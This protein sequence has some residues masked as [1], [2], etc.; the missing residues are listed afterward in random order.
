MVAGPSR[1]GRTGCDIRIA[2][3]P[4]GADR[5]SRH[6]RG[7]RARGPDRRGRGRVRPGD[8]LQPRPARLPAS[9]PHRRGRG[10]CHP[11]RTDHLLRPAG[12]PRGAPGHRR[13]GGG[14][15][16]PGP[17]PASGW[18]CTPGG[19]PP[20]GSTQ[21][22]Y[23]EPGD[24]VIYPSPGYP[25]F[26]SF[27]RYIGGVPVPLRL[28][29]ESGFNFTG[30]DL[31]RLITARTKMIYLN[32]PSNP[33]G[34]VASREQLA[35][36]AAVILERTAPRPGCTRTRPT[37]PSSSTGPA[38]SRSPRCRAWRSAPSSPPAPP[39]PTRGPGGRVGWGVFPTG[40]RGPGPAAS[41]HQL[42]RLDPALQPTGGQDGAGVAGVPAGDRGDGVGLPAATRPGGG[43]AQRHRRDHLPEPA[44]RLLRVSQRLRGAAAPRRPGPVRGTAGRGQAAVRRRPPCCSCSC[45][46][47]TGWPPWTAARSVCSAP[48]AST[49]CGSPS[50]P[51][52]R[53][54]PRRCSGSPAA[55]GDA[56]GFGEFVSSGRRLTL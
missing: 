11:L 30:E 32:F 33:T 19:A 46:T 23:L 5:R 16:G 49:S 3:A 34:G 55:S 27:I 38:T 12:A 25:L 21:H 26:E 22:A 8:P 41:Q 10:R 31:G 14:G 35:E 29:E 36:I 40:R 42:L 52:T 6:R 43:S 24:E 7:L 17:R 9:R 44:R 13:Q 1:A 50:P 51:A 39:R 15:S 47:G 56:A 48:R 28:R 4:H 37:R 2:A 20:S 53:T 45:C 54:S 18:W